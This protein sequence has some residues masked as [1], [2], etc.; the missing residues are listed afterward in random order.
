MVLGVAATTGGAGLAFTLLWASGL[1]PVNRK[2]S[3]E[4]QEKKN[5]PASSMTSIGSRFF[6][7]MGFKLRL[8]EINGDILTATGPEKWLA[9]YLSALFD[10]P[11][12]SLKF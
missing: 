1:V 9:A 12:L 3:P 8:K 11:S 10:T 4:L 7:C 5:W 2:C 6:I